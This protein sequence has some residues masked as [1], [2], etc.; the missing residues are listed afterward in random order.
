MINKRKIAIIH[1]WLVNPGGG[2]KVLEK[3]ISIYPH[4]DLFS[5]VDFLDDK[6]RALISNK[7]V[8]TSFI[9]RLPFAK[10]KYRSYLPLMPLAIEQFDMNGY[11]LVISSSHAVAKGII[12]GP[13]QL[14]ICYCHTPIRYAWD[15]QGQYLKESK[16]EKGLKSCLA[17]WILHRIRLWDYRTAAGVDYFIANSKYI[18]RRIHKVY[19]KKADVIYPNVAVNDF[20]SINEKENYYFTASRMVPYKKIDLIVRAFNKMPDKALVVIGEGPQYEM[21]KKVAAKNITLLGYQDFEIL[22]EKMSHA[23]AFVF[24][25]EED[26][27]IIPVEAQACGTP[28]IAFGR[29]GALETVIPVGR[30]DP[31]GIFFDEQTEDSIIDAVN[32]FEIVRPE[33]TSEA[34]R[35]NANRFSDERFI[36]EFK[37]FV[38]DKWAQFE[39][40]K[41]T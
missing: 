21:V 28:V 32:R 16:L 27:G 34:C 12:T 19:N 9:Q 13:N 18:A 25:A 29:G 33:I 41:F 40:M 20:E 26:F 30:E 11:D 15:M 8:K 37:D 14:H 36:N 3:I 6:N 5:L 23:K 22:K 10:S 24:A 2:E 4:A 1:D 39:N 38:E 17:R 35:K 7:I 31:T